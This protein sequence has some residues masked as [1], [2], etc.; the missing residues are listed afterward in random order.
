[1]PFA[2][3][4]DWPDGT[5]CNVVQSTDNAFCT[6]LS[7]IPNAVVK[8]YDFNQ[9]GDYNFTAYPNEPGRLHGWSYGYIRTGPIYKFIGSLAEDS[10]FTLI[11]TDVQKAELIIEKDCRGL[12]LEGAFD[13]FRLLLT[14]GNEQT[15]FDKYFNLLGVTL[16]PAAKPIFGY[17]S[18]YRHYQNILSSYEHTVIRRIEER[19]SAEELEKFDEILAVMSRELM[20]ECD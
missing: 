20:P 6:G 12:H 10:G 3:F 16:R 8:K 15:V 7:R 9:Y 17:T 18:W 11:R 4:I 5:G 1:M 14:E 13:A 2:D 19:F